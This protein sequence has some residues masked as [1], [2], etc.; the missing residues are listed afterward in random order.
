MLS[1]DAVWLSVYTVH[2]TEY[3]IADSAV[4]EP[5]RRNNTWLEPQNSFSR[6]LFMLLP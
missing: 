3:S 6:I 5:L 1:L 2:R 4:G